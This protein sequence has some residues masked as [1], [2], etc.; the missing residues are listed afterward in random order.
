MMPLRLPSEAA[1]IACF[2]KESKVWFVVDKKLYSFNAATESFF[3][4]KQVE[5]IKSYDGPSYYHRG[6]LYCSNYEG[7]AKKLEIGQL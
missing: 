7:A 6:Y 1:N 5:G 3:L 2:S 4:I